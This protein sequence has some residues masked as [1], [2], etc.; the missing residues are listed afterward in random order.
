M[1]NKNPKLINYHQDEIF[2]KLDQYAKLI[3]G[4]LPFDSANGLCSGLI[5]YALYCEMRDIEYEFLLELNYVLKWKSNEFKKLDLQKDAIF[6]RFINNVTSLHFVHNLRYGENI[7]QRQLDKNLAFTDY[8]RQLKASELTFVFTKENLCLLINDQAVPETWIR[9]ENGFHAA[10]L[11]YKN[12]VYK[13]YNFENP[14]GPKI[15]LT[16]DKVAQVIFDDLAK[17][18]HS[19]KHIALNFR[20]YNLIDEVAAFPTLEEYARE[21]FA[22]PEYKEAI[23]SHQNIFH[24]AARMEDYELM[25]LLFAEGYEYIPWQLD[26]YPEINEAIIENNKEMLQY[27]LDHNISTD[28]RTETGMTPIGEAITYN[29]MELLFELLEAGADLNEDACEDVSTLELALDNDSPEAVVLL[30]AF[31]LDVT[32]DQLEHLFIYFNEQQI[33]E[34]KNLAVAFNAKILGVKNDFDIN[35]ADFKLLIAFLHHL[36]MQVQLGK[37][38]NNDELAVILKQIAARFYEPQDN[39]SEFSK[40]LEMYNLLQN[41]KIKGFKSKATRHLINSLD[42][43]T[44]KILKM[45]YGYYSAQDRQDIATTLKVIEDILSF[46]SELKVNFYSRHKVYQAKRKIEKHIETYH[47]LQ[48][49]HKS[50]PQHLLFGS[51]NC[52]LTTPIQFN[53]DIKK[54]L[55]LGKK[56]Q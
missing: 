7:A 25:D 15:F 40:K 22:D 35:T 6:E 42:N 10:G 17:H 23:L 27:L 41:F 18:C 19:K 1:P 53:E 21:L 30:L 2:K 49:F 12:G 34:I 52:Q 37:G 11:I 36:K 45:P 4:T 32:E 38:P 26:R 5:A 9:I 8:T 39:L 43:V 31:E 46:R 33:D 48:S 47:T 13:L 20:I 50:R 16:A 55:S 24:L 54:E 56:R 28:A 44:K 14:E 51:N 29:N 3:G